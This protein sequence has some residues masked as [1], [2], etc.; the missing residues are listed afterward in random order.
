MSVIRQV[1]NMLVHLTMSKDALINKIKPELNERKNQVGGAG[2][3]RP[4]STKNKMSSWQKGKKKGPHK[5]GPAISRA[6]KGV[7]KSK[8]HKLAAAKARKAVGNKPW[9]KLRWELHFAKG[10]KRNKS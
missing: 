2:L 3:I 8:R 4:A 10:K 7:P 9:S 6:L 5:G 1:V